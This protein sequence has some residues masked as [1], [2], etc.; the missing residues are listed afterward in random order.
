ELYNAAE[1]G[2]IK[3]VEAALQHTPDINW[4][5]PDFFG[6]TPL[7]IASK[8][9]HADVI[10]KLVASGADVNKVDIF[11]QTP[12]YIASKRGHADVIE[13]LVASGAD[14]NKVDIFG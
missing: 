14:V 6:Q 10:E 12:L 7:Y 1:A 9:G 3:R 11:G 4:G 2:D 5:N 13:K 8:R